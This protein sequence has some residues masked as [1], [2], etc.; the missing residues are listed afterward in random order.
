MVILLYTKVVRS[1]VVQYQPLNFFHFP[2][3]FPAAMKGN[4][5]ACLWLLDHHGGGLS[6]SIH[7]QADRDGFT[8]AKFAS[9]NGFEELGGVLLKYEMEIEKGVV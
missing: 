8:P 4:K 2:F 5:E 1:F 7:M 3:P 6:P 9:N